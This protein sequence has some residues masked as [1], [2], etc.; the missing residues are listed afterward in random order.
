[1]AVERFT[2]AM[3]TQSRGWT[4][5]ARQLAIVGALDPR[6]CRA[7]IGTG[8][9][10]VRRMASERQQLGFWYLFCVGLSVRGSCC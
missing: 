9:E 1:L 6:P 10:E 8:R 7:R 2:G 5:S 3:T 4:Q